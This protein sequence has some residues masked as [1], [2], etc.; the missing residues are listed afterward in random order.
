MSLNNPFGSKRE[1]IPAAKIDVGAEFLDFVPQEFMVDP[2]GYFE[3]KGVNIKQGDIKKDETG[4]VREDPTAVRDL[5]PW[6]NK[7]GVRLH[8]VGKRVNV[9]KG[10]VGE[11]GDPFY[12]YKILERLHE[13]HLPAARPVAKAERDGNHLIVMSRIPGVRWSEKESLRLRDRGYSDSEI[14]QLQAQ[15]SQKMEA[16]KQ[17][18]E[19]VGISRVWKLKDMVFD[20]DIENKKI[21][22]VVPTDWERTKIQE[23][24]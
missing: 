14:T 10:F 12:E 19:A 17:Q 16:M 20:I 11:S 9:R 22:S 1:K 18:F 24:V 3:R 4:R 15:A 13:L 5:P 2:F 21:I 8:I 23:K 7:D 6:H